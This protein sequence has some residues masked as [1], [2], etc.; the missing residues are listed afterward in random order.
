[1]KLMSAF[2]LCLLGLLSG[3]ALAETTA[4]AAGTDAC[5]LVGPLNGATEDC[6]ARRIAFRTEVQ[7]CMEQMHAEADARAGKPTKINAHTSRA[8]F[9]MCD[10]ATR[11]RLSL[12]TD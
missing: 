11:E 1:M 7:I 5:P 2:P 6:K 8:R 12:W 9:L 3:P 10:A 4:G